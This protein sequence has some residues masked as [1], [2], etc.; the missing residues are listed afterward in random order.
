M[1]YSS[2]LALNLSASS[3]CRRTSSRRA[4]LRTETSS[5]DMGSVALGSPWKSGRLFLRCSGVG[6]GTLCNTRTQLM[7]R[8][9]QGEQLPRSSLIQIVHFNTHPKLHNPRILCVRH[10]IGHPTGILDAKY[11]RSHGITGRGQGVL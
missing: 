8:S 9:S 5:R 7:R 11:L 2:G 10:G 4:E 1:R 6:A 3:A